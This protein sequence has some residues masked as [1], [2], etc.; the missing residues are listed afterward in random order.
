MS[1]FRKPIFFQE[2]HNNNVPEGLLLAMFAASVRFFTESKALQLFG[3]DPRHAGDALASHAHRIMNEVSRGT[4]AALLYAFKTEIILT[5][6]AL[7]STP[8]L[9]IADRVGR[10]VRLAYTYGL[11]QV[12]NPGQCILCSDSMTTSDQEELRYVWWNIHSLDMIC[13]MATGMACNSG[14]NKIYTAVLS[15]SADQFS[16]D[17]IA[18]S[19]RLFLGPDIKTIELSTQEI[20]LEP[21]SRPFNICLLIRFILEDIY[22]TY[23]HSRQSLEH[24][25]LGLHRANLQAALVSIKESVSRSLV[26]AGSYNVDSSGSLSYSHHYQ[27]Q[28]QLY[29]SLSE[30]LLHI[31]IGLLY[32]R[33]DAYF[34][35]QH[36]DWD[37][38]REHIDQFLI[39]I[40]QWDSR[41]FL[42]VSPFVS[43]AVWTVAALLL[44]QAKLKLPCKSGSFGDGTAKSVAMLDLF[45]M[46]SGNHWWLSKTLAGKF[47]T[48]TI[49]FVLLFLSIFCPST[50]HYEYSV[51]DLDTH[52]LSRF[53]QEIRNRSSVL[54]RRLRS[55]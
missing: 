42:C 24:S 20:D 43:L 7:S 26:T 1:L 13:S 44:L 41:Y 4:T 3:M 23:R 5:F 39:T 33:S 54:S 55:S 31:P 9:S 48:T 6:H 2:Y 35:K 47:F 53:H 50:L 18:G 45:L 25:N 14:I 37:R 8:S 28:F 19:K 29:I 10:L 22:S 38:C 27:V 36:N 16:S 17:N 30:I 51:T 15:C 40:K 12:D 21:S 32:S 49:A 46:A 11:H 34:S 52:D